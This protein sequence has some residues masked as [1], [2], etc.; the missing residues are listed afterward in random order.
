MYRRLSAR[1]CANASA[2]ML[3]AAVRERLRIVD[4][5]YDD[6]EVHI[7]R[8]EK[9]VLT[10]GFN[11]ELAEATARTTTVMNSYN[12]LLRDMQDGHS[13]VWQPEAVVT[14]IRKRYE[15]KMICLDQRLGRLPG[16]RYTVVGGVVAG[17]VLLMFFVHV[18]RNG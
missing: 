9:A 2:G 8:A 7:A 15:G 14:A 13:P 10:R 6:A 5:D 16:H 17:T 4:L 11:A 3:P 1:L 18:V 12:G